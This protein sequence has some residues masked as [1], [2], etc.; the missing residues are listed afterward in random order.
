MFL[1]SIYSDASWN[2]LDIVSGNIFCLPGIWAADIWVPF[3]MH[4]IQIYLVN[5]LHEAYCVPPYLFMY[6]IAVELLDMIFKCL[7]R[8]L[9]GKNDFLASI[10]ARSFK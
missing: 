6:A 1:D 8:F 5:W 3:S 4:I 9:R 7:T 10:I 2:F